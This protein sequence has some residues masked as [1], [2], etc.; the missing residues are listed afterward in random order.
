MAGHPRLD[1]PPNV[2][3]LP[4]LIAAPD[5]GGADQA[6]FDHRWMGGERDATRDHA[7][8]LARDLEQLPVG[9]LAPTTGITVLAALPLSGQAVAAGPPWSVVAGLRCTP[10]VAWLALLAAR[11]APTFSAIDHY[12]DRILMGWHAAGAAWLRAVGEDEI[13]TPYLPDVVQALLPAPG[14]ARPYAASIARLAASH[15]DQPPG[16]VTRIAQGLSSRRPMRLL[17]AWRR[18]FF[19]PPGLDLATWLGKARG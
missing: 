19:L 3:S 1:A 14:E 17:R 6:W 13:L 2:V 4:Q 11:M 15:L 18:G 9:S 10:P 5:H 16:E 8:Q 7:K 12:E